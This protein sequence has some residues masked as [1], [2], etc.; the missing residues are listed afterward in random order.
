[1]GVL[2]GKV[3]YL[4]VAG[5]CCWVAGW[6]LGAATDQAVEAEER[7]ESTRTCLAAISVGIL[8]LLLGSMFYVRDL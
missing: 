5:L 4:V 3:V 1:M 6:S 2:I 8:M 7:G